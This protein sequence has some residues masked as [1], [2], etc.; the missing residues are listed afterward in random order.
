MHAYKRQLLNAFKIMDLYNRLLEDPDFDMVPHT[1]IFAGKAAQS[2]SFA[3]AVIKLINSLADVINNDE[4]I[5]GKIKV[6]FLKNFNVSL[7][8]MIYPAADISEQ[9]STAGM[10]ASGT[11]NMKFMFN[12]AVTLGTLDGANVEILEQVGAEN[13]KIF[14]LKSEEVS[15]LRANHNYNVWMEFTEDNRI[16]KILSQLRDGTFC[17]NTD[18]FN[19]IYDSLMHSN[20]YFFVLKDFHA[21]VDAWKDLNDIYKEKNQWQVMSLNNIASAGY[22]SSDRTID[23]YVDDIWHTLRRNKT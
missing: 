8:Q 19:E 20:D 2:Y 21:Y 22:F 6:V 15:D 9:I 3:K 17:K 11:G 1:F 10:E 23:E 13:I 14:G 5:G 12:G 16:S 7:A 4:R 18:E